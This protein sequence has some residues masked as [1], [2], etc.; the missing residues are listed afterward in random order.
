[1]RI[2]LVCVCV[3]V[4]IMATAVS[5][6]EEKDEYEQYFSVKS[7]ANCCSVSR[8]CASR[9]FFT[10]TVLPLETSRELLQLP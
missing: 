8:L 10:A 2:I 6:E 9:V 3:C 4:S 5:E 1:M 7:I